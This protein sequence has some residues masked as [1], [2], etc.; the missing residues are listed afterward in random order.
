VTMQVRLAVH[1]GGYKPG[2]VLLV[3]DAAARRLIADG[4]GT[5]D[6]SAPSGRPRKDELLRRAEELG[7][8]VDGLKTNAEL[9]AA[10]DAAVPAATSPTTTVMPVMPADTEGDTD[11]R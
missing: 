6:E 1:W 11:G 7:V 10:I 8:N 2:D 4:H 3:E 5:L 9:Q